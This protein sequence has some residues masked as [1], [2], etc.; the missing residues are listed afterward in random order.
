MIWPP[1]EFRGHGAFFAQPPLPAEKPG[2]PSNAN[3]RSCHLSSGFYFVGGHIVK[4]VYHLMCCFQPVSPSIM[5]TRCYIIRM[6]LWSATGRSLRLVL[7]SWS[8]TTISIKTGSN[9]S[10]TT[11]SLTATTITTTTPTIATTQKDNYPTPHPS[12]TPLMCHP[13]NYRGSFTRLLVCHCLPVCP[14]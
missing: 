11:T 9:P 1:S 13:W 5:Y 2:H 3:I 12:M 6:G 14:K 8:Q 4:P 7:Q 10:T